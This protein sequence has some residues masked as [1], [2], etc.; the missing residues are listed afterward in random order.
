[1]KR[2]YQ[3]M[4]SKK[5]KNSPIREALYRIL[6]ENQD[7]CLSF[8]DIQV[9][10]SQNHIKNISQNTIYRHLGFFA[11]C[12]LVITIQDNFKKSYYTL[13]RDKPLAF[14]IC[15]RCNKVKKITF[16]SEK[17]DEILED[18]DFIVIYK[19]CKKCY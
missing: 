5:A 19:K 1:M 6:L 11:S 13:T 9:E 3:C 15:K 7:R 8:T 2:L 4:K 18:M 17:C 14:T 10:L 16:H 12:N